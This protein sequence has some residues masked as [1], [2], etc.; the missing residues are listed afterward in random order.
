MT[1]NDAH[2]FC[3]PDQ[4]KEEF[5]KV[6]QL[7]EQ[8]YK[9]L[10]ITKYTLPVVAARRREEGKV[11]RQS[12]NVGARRARVA[13]GHGFSRPAVRG[14]PG[15]GGVLRTQARY[16]TC[17]RHGARRDVFHHSGGFP[18][19]H[20]VRIEIYR[21]RRQGAPSGD[22]PSRHREHHGAHDLLPDR[23]VRRS[24]SAVAR[25]RCRRSCCPS[26][27]ARPNTPAAS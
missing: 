18:P 23:A 8:A 20:P 22:D 4:I 19:A 12:R 15:R 7:V 3:R 27:T 1:L 21:R 9:D 2:I 24:V 5:T 14:S 6:M 25:A 13:R 26:P 16:P 11:R 17:R 10:G